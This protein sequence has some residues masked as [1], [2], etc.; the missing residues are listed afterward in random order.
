MKIAIVLFNL[1]AVAG[2]FMVFGMSKNPIN[3]G[4]GMLCSMCVMYGAM[5]K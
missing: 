5:R 3:L 2:N 1:A 4:I